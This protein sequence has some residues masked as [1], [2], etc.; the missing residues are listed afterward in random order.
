V[1]CVGCQPTV[2]ALDTAGAEG[3]AITRL[4]WFLIILGTVVFVIVV[5]VLIAGLLQ[6]RKGV[7]HDVDLTPRGSAFVMVG[8]AIIPT[9]ILALVFIMSVRAGVP[10]FT[11]NDARTFRITGHQWWWDVEYI[12]S[13]PSRR[14]HT[15]N[16]LHVPIGE[17]IRVLAESRDVIH[18]FWIPQLQGKTD[19]IPGTTNVFWIRALRPGTYRGQCA[20]YCG[21]QHSLMAFTIIAESPA[22]FRAWLAGQEEPAR[23]SPPSD[24]M[25]FAG[26]T[27]FANATCA[28]CHSVR[29]TNARGQVGPDLTHV[30]SRLTLAAGTLPNTLAAMQAWI[31]NAQSLKPGALMPSMPVYDGPSLRALAAYLMNL[32]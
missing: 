27:I 1:C 29:G 26:R 10:A 31:T 17:S 12:D 14:F 23:D 24:S 18:S 4:A 7:A 32:R 20:E 15:A 30:G 19:L 9:L 6:E 21:L 28:T 2:S 13:S 16:E 11:R 25:T 5:G 22:R 8:G 3:T